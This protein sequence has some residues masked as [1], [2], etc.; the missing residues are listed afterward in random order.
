[1]KSGSQESLGSLGVFLFDVCRLRFVICHLRRTAQTIMTKVIHET[2]MKNVKRQITKLP[3]FPD[4]PDFL[5]SQTFQ[6]P[7]SRLLL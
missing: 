3:D 1:M 4:F 2:K 5:D 6:T 7:D